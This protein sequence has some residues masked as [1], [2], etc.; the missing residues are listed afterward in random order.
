[1]AA[2]DNG[3]PFGLILS[4][5]SSACYEYEQQ[6]CKSKKSVWLVP[7]VISWRE[8]SGIITWRC[9]W[10]NSCESRCI[11]ATIKARSDRR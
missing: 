5:K 8:D 6:S 1:M 4:P 2:N 3:A 9:N 11:Y 7:H 10:G